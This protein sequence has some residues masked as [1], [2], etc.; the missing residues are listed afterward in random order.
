MENKVHEAVEVLVQ[1]LKD[2]PQYKMA[3]VANIAMSFQDEW[4]RSVKEDEHTDVHK[5][6]NAAAEN[7]LELLCFTGS[8]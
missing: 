3:W 5:I 7:F 1:A 2:D 4:H 6:S 8:K